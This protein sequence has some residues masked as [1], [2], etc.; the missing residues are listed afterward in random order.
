MFRRG[1][2]VG[3]LGA[4]AANLPEQ[5]VRIAYGPDAYSV[6]MAMN[7]AGFANPASPA[8]I[9]LGVRPAPDGGSMVQRT[10]DDRWYSPIQN[11]KGMRSN[12]T[13]PA[14]KTLK[15]AGSLPSGNQSIDP[16][17]LAWTPDLWSGVGS[18]TGNNGVSG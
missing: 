18:W 7:N 5:Q 3:V 17:L 15:P 12:I 6:Q 11:F 14:L 4:P 10:K 2:G 1:K 16:T 9:G 13:N 8:S